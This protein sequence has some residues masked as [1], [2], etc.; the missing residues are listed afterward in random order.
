MTNTSNKK[1]FN[2]DPLEWMDSDTDEDSSE[3]EAVSRGP[4]SMPAEDLGDTLKL[5]SVL[6]IESVGALHSRFVEILQQRD[7]FEI[8]ASNVE[9]VDTTT[10][11]LL[12]ALLKETNASNQQYRIS[13]ASEQFMDSA[14]MLGVVDLLGVNS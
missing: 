12:I 4:D 10:L 13:N 11:Q 5:N 2:K 8:D 14:R 7:S 1:G 3:S 9:S 6:N